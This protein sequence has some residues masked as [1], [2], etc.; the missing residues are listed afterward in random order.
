MLDIWGTWWYA[1]SSKDFTELC[2]GGLT[3]CIHTTSTLDWLHPL[4]VAFIS[5]NSLPESS[6][7]V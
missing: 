3:S 5:R 2:S 1:M 7:V 6:A 4:S